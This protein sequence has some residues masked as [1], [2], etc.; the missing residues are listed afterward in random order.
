MDELKR[1]INIK[2]DQ[3]R[4]IKIMM[5]SFTNKLLAP[6]TNSMKS[7]IRNNA[8]YSY[9]LKEYDTMLDKLLIKKDKK[10]IK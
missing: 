2:E 3:E 5:N 6:Y 1:K 10:I 4:V 7:F 8:N 9:I